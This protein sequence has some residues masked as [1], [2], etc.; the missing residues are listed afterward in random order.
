MDIFSLAF[1]YAPCQVDQ[2]EENRQIN[3]DGSH[4]CYPTQFKCIKPINKERDPKSSQHKGSFGDPDALR[5][6]GEDFLAPFGHELVEQFPDGARTMVL[7]TRPKLVLLDEPTAGMTPDETHRVT[8]LVKS[9]A[10]TGNYTF[11]ITEHDMSV[12]FDVADRILVMFAGRIMGERRR[13]G[14]SLG[15]AQ[16]VPAGGASDR[17][18]ARHLG[19]QHDAIVA[20]LVEGQAADLVGPPEQHLL[21]VRQD[22]PYERRRGGHHGLLARPLPGREDGGRPRRRAD[23]VPGR[24]RR[25]PPPIP[26]PWQR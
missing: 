8:A 19:A 12:V 24:R 23:R 26:G 11:L 14:K 10:Q 17:H 7:A 22:A 21:P 6:L 9:L 15:S 2:V 4:M 25:R 5:A 20:L 3:E 13:K 16:R 1:A 18:A